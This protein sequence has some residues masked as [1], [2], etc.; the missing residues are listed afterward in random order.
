MDDLAVADMGT[1]GHYLTLDSPRNNKQQAVHPIPI[2]IPNG[3]I[4]TS[5]HTALLYHP[6]LLLQAQQ[7]HI[8]PGINKALLYIG[9][10]CDHGYEATFN[11]KYVCILNK[12]SGKIIMSGT[13]DTR[14]NLYMLNL[15]QK[16]KLMTES[17]T[18]DEYFAGSA[19]ECKSKSTLV[20]YHH[21]SC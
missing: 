11:D 17:T 6:D 18:P 15:T 7:A 8:F 5:M 1:T 12:Q 20:D 9:K 2:Q 19:Y 13:R 16:K 21:A 10:L 14:T 4:T 3:E